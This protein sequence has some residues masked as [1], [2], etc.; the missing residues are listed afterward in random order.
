[1]KFIILTLLFSTSLFAQTNTDLLKKLVKNEGHGVVVKI[2]DTPT[3]KNKFTVVYVF[4]EIKL[5]PRDVLYF[6]VPE[7]YAKLNISRLGFSHR[8]KGEFVERDLKPGLTSALVYSK[9]VPGDEYRYWG[10]PSSGELGAKFAEN[11]PYPEYDGLY[12]WPKKGHR[13]LRNSKKIFKLISANVI[14][15][16]NLGTD[17]VYVSK[18][19]FEFMP[20]IPAVEKVHIFTPGSHFGDPYTMSGRTYGGGQNHQGTFPNAISLN[21]KYEYDETNLPRDF[22]VSKNKLFIKV[23]KENNFSFIEIMCGD[24][25]P[26]RAINRDGGYGSPGNAEVSVSIENLYSGIKRTL[27]K[28]ISIPPEG[29]IMISEINNEIKLEEGDR[30]VVTNKVNKSTLYIMA[31]RM[32]L[33]DVKP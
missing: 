29:V 9:S 7:E 14:R 20:N 2:F 11:S 27:A 13:G 1:M 30:L 21:S 6:Y 22:T 23:P 15:L 31:I 19:D 16:Q 5:K 10:G 8:Q 25:R 4:P 17:D 12:E 32:G 26:D 3:S 24:S 33:D 28:N 18:L